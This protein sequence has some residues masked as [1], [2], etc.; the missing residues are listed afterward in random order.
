LIIVDR[1]EGSTTGRLLAE[2]LTLADE[3]GIVN[4]TGRRNTESSALNAASYTDK[5]RQLEALE[6]GGVPC[7]PFRT[8]MPREEGWLPRRRLHHNGLDFRKRR[9]KFKPDY[10][11]KFIE[12]A[13]EWRL[14]V[15]KTAKGNYRIIRSGLKVAKDDDAHPWV[16]GHRQG[17]K[18]SY[19]GGAPTPV[20]E[21]SRAALDALGLDFGAVDIGVKRNGHPVVIEVNTC[22]GLDTGTLQIYIKQIKE[23]FDAETRM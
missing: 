21:A 19:V 7:T 15:F 1:K 14:H 18:I 12:L 23:R 16:R 22:P 6:Q 13:Q 4:W 10:W 17:W 3:D 20:K 11:T 9:K 5:L 2:Q 8:D